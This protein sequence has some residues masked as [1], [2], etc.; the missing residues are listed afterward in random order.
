MPAD[1]FYAGEQRKG[2][3]EI[4]DHCSSFSEHVRTA[5]RG[6]FPLSFETPLPREVKGAALFIRDTDPDAILRFWG[7]HLSGL[8]KLVLDAEPSQLIWDS[9]IPSAIRPAAG[10]LKTVALAQLFRHHGIG[11]Q[12]WLCQFANGF[13]ITSDL[14]QRDVFPASVKRIPSRIPVASFSTQLP[15]VFGN[16][17][18][19][20]VKR[21]PFSYGRK[22]PARSKRVGWLLPSCSTRTVVHAA[23]N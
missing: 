2:I 15:L 19:N 3:R 6:M 20:R 11:E 9:Q 17:Q 1:L 22:L 23:G 21:T 8:E 14:S 12:R 7:R 4:P 16:V 10:K 18:P 13:P 5:L